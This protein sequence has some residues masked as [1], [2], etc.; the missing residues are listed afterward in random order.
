MIDPNT[1]ITD[2]Y[3][4]ASQNNTEQVLKFLDM[5]VPPTY[6]D[7]K[8]GLTVKEIISQ[9]KCIF[10]LLVFHRLCIGHQ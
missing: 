4:A 1:L 7:N 3:V 9:W 10:L 8:T 2:L 5:R 6:Y